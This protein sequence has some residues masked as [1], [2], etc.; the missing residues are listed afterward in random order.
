MNHA[1]WLECTLTAVL[2]FIVIYLADIT[3]MLPEMGLKKLP[4]MTPQP[5]VDSLTC[6][7]W[8][9]FLWECACRVTASEWHWSPVGILVVDRI[10]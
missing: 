4:S 6:I 5:D 7:G 9:G 8:K 1:V 2:I 10:L 3:Y